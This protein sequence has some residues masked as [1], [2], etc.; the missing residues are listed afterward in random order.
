MVKKRHPFFRFFWTLFWLGFPKHKV[1]GLESIPKDRPAVYV[2]NHA[3]AY[4]PIV[5]VMSFNRRFRPWV[6]AETCSIKTIRN[7]FAREFLKAETRTGKFFMGIIGA[8]IAP[9]AI[10][11]LRAVEA[12]PVYP[13]TRLVT[14]F[15]QSVQSLKSGINLVIFP[16]N[17]ET[18]SEFTKNFNTGFVHV[19]R[20]YYK[21]TGK[22]LEFYPVYASMKY[23]TVK[24][25]MPTIFDPEDDFDLQKER[26]AKYLR[27]AVTRIADEQKKRHGG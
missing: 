8:I 16:E 15:N 5:M 2:C 24:I 22:R 9:L 23:R 12:I 1:F 18:F 3:G 6:L 19:A 27:D 26:V 14:T 7:V 20:K 10:M 25:G 11:V 17:D 4:G 21:E 13:D